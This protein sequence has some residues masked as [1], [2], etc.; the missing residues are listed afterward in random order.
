MRAAVFSTHGF[1]RDA[2]ERANAQHGHEL[3][4]LEP[5]LDRSTVSLAE[6]FPA[7][8]AFVNDSLDAAVLEL[9]NKGGTRLIA[10][11]SAGFNN[12]DLAAAR[13]LGFKVVR[14]PAYSPHCVAEHAFALLLALIRHIPQAYN[15]VRDE[16]FS[17]EGLVG[18]E[19]HGRTFAV[20]GA[21]RIGL[22]VAR[23]AHGFGCKV[24]AVDPAPAAVGN[25]GFPLEFVSLDH[26]A[27][28]ADVLSL[29]APLTT[30]AFHLIDAACLA[31]MK[32]SAIIINTGRG[33]LI[34]TTA[35]IAALKEG[36]IGGVGLDVYEQEES[37]F[38]KDLS[39]KILEDDAL[40]RLLTFRNVLVT[41][42]IGFLT[43]E[44]ID[45][46][47]ATTLASLAAFEHGEKLTC[48]IN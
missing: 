30:G 28:V 20:V 3:A 18:L 45:E 19:L 15:R 8:V 4:F 43:R 6:G 1:E 36:R 12:V 25:I 21:G 31:R 32:P 39:D 11:R 7:V 35:L 34:D 26:A 9:L 27:A 24:I 38:Y 16:N 48:E 17:V 40:A 10:L 5:R 44:A 47:A 37:V 13:R 46:I 2:L 42:H 14:V 22:S 23:I 41:S 33:A 29:H